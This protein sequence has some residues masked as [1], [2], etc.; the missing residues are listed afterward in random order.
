M[1]NVIT[2]FFDDA[3]RARAVRQELVVRQ[4]FP[5]GI[6]FVYDKR[7]GFLERMAGLKIDDRAAQTY[8]DRMSNGGAM[9]LVRAGYQPLG[10]ARI[11]RETMDE[12][13]SVYFGEDLVEEV[14]VKDERQPLLSVMTGHPHILT[15]PKNPDMT[16]VH[17][18]NWPIPLISR[19]KPFNETIIPRHGRMA[20]WP[21]PLTNRHKPFSETLFER[22]A[23]MA[24]W[25]IPLLSDRKPF[26]GSIFSR[27]ARMANFPLPLISR[28]KPFTG[29]LIG[30][31]SRMANWPFPHLING[32]PSNNALI[33]NGPRMANFPISLLSSRKPFTGSIFSRHARMAN[34]PIGLISKRKP[35]TASIIPRHGRMAAWPIPLIS[36]RSNM[37]QGGPQSF[38]LSRM[39]G[40]PTVVRR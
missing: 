16:T 5:P 30:K 33:P 1:T 20:A 40:L 4:N 23:H 27:H 28:R 18:A 24:N 32:K 9:V 21:F 29:T 34:F 26:T 2:R 37:K 3:A 6:V 36:R 14:R 39:L 35:I 25:P 8:H 15:R 12:M 17:M 38:S 19:R 10:V 22:H 13:G 11:A 31:H 7:D